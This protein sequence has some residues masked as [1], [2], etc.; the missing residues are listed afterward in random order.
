MR[1]AAALILLTA[2]SEAS[3]RFEDAREGLPIEHVYQGGWEHFVGGGV[4]ALDCNHDGFLDLFA[5][6]GT[7]PA[8]LFVN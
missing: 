3:P 4:A 2:P 6:G 8:Q 7:N 5:A 1:L